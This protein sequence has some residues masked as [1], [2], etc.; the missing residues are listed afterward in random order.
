MIVWSQIV[1]LKYGPDGSLFMIDWYDKNQCHH[2]DVERPRPHQ[3]ADLQGQLTARP[4]TSRS[5]LAKE[6]S[7]AL[8]AACRPR[9]TNGMPGT[10][11]GFSRSAGRARGRRPAASRAG[12]EE[13]ERARGPASHPARTA[14]ACRR[15]RPEAD[16]DRRSSG[17]SL[18]AEHRRAPTRFAPGRF[19]LGRP[20]RGLRPACRSAFWRTIL[21]SSPRERDPSPVVRLYLASALQRLPLEERWE[22][23][24]RPGRPWRGCR[25]SQPCRSCTG[26]PPSRWPRSTPRGAATGGCSSRI[27]RIQEFMARRIGALGTPESLA[28]LVDELGRAAG[29][30]RRSTLLIGIEEGAARPPPGGDARRLAGGLRDARRRR[31][32]G[33]SLAGGRAGRDLRRPGGADPPLRQSARR[34]TRR[35]SPS[36]RAGAGGPAQGEGPGAAADV[37]HGLVRHPRARRPG[38]PWAVGLRRPGD[39]GAS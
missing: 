37:L 20:S 35:T 23:A 5:D 16:P 34:L 10:R 36:E 12:L 39:A 2:N 27:S 11:G 25:R 17:P 28:L 21:P 14:A 22:I 9:P 29:S 7:E 33:R 3:R 6:S 26:M 24:R 15:D 13:P 8:V 32:R 30:A 31:R 19:R 38:D 4:S 1:S 18:V